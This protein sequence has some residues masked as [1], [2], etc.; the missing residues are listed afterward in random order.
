MEGIVFQPDASDQE[1]GNEIISLL[2]KEKE[3]P[4]FNTFTELEVFHKVVLKLDIKST[5]ALLSEKRA[6]RRLLEKTR[7]EEDKK[8]ELIVLYL[9]HL[10]RKYI[11]KQ[12]LSNNNK[13]ISMGVD[14]TSSYPP[15]PSD[16]GSEVSTSG[17]DSDFS[18]ES[19]GVGLDNKQSGNGNKEGSSC[20]RHLFV[21]PEE[22]RCPISLQ[23]MSD[24]VIISSGQTYERAC[25]EKWFK[26]GHDTCP[27]TQQ[28]LAHL[29]IT[30]NYCVKGLIV[31]WCERQSIPLPIP[32][33]LPLQSKCFSVKN[34]EN[35]YLEHEDKPSDLRQG[36]EGEKLHQCIPN[37]DINAYVDDL[38]DRIIVKD[39]TKNKVELVMN[40]LCTS[41][42]DIQC[43]AAREIRYLTKDDEGARAL[44]GHLGCIPPLVGILRNAMKALDENAVIMTCLALSNITVNNDR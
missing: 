17:L 33:S 22:F 4:G 21:P 35:R 16:R 20:L 19:C 3:F 1:V 31:S 11:K 24:P 8:K 26:E 27:K 18:S 6:L 13:E 28:T 12:N 42:L 14:V 30:P 10:L 5:K 23:L 43:S 9:L 36:V 41:S 44:F 38:P 40:R 2:H 37:L 34:M 7:K 29:Q 25:I 39:D 15:S 32:P